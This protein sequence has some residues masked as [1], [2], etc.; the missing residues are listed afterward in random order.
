MKFR[1]LLT[2]IAFLTTPVIAGEHVRGKSVAGWPGVKY[3]KVVGYYFVPELDGKFST[4]DENGL[5]VDDLAKYK[6]Q[7][8]ALQPRQIDHLLQAGFA[9]KVHFPRAACYAPHHVFVFYNQAGQP[10]A[11]CEFC[12]S[13]KGFATWPDEKPPRQPNDQRARNYVAL[14]LLCGELGLKL[15]PTGPP[16]KKVVNQMREELRAQR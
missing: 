8:Q 16:L 4:I 10:V 12:L 9:S 13:C 15:D 5:R 2:V 14:A 7:E 11:A 6:L 3:A 1:T